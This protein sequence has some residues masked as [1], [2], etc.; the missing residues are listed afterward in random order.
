MRPMI[1][2]HSAAGVRGT[3]SGSRYGLPDRKGDVL[4]R[5]MPTLHPT[6]PVIVATGQGADS[7]RDIIKGEPNFAFATP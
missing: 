5:G 3:K 7:I 1:A 2:A 4:I 6:L